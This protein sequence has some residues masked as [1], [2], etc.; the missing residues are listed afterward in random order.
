MPEGPVP[1][2]DPTL[3][4][5]QLPEAEQLAFLHTVLTDQEFAEDGRLEQGLIC[6]E[7]G[8]QYARESEIEGEEW[9]SPLVECYHLALDLYGWH[10]GSRLMR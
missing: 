10:Y 1:F 9:G 7:I 2:P 8:L 4:L 5:R 6:L 3:L